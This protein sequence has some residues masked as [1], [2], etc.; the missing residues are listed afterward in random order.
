MKKIFTL[1]SLLCLFSIAT[2]A[3]QSRMVLWEQFTNTSCGPCAGFNP[4]AEAYWEENADKVVPISFHVSWPGANDPM[5]QNNTEENSWRRNLYGCNSVPWTTINGNVFNANPNMGTIQS[6]INSE[7]ALTPKFDITLSHELN[8][9]NSAVTVNMTVKANED[10]SGD[11]LAHIVIIEK[12]IDFDTPPGSN[13]EKHFVNVMKKFLPNKTGNALPA[14]MSAGETI[15]ISQ[16]WTISGFYNVTYL[17]AAGFVQNTSDKYIY[18]AAFSAP[19]APAYNDVVA[20][21]II[22]PDGSVCGSAIEP[23]LK[24]KNNGAILTSVDISYQLND[25]A[26]QTYTYEGSIPFLGAVSIPLPALSSAALTPTGNTLTVTLSNPNGGDDNN[27]ANNEVSTTFNNTSV[28]QRVFMESKLGTYAEELSWK[29][30]DYNGNII[31]EAQYTSA[32]SNTTVK[33]TFSFPITGCYR[34]VWHDSYGDGFNGGGW[35][36][37]TA[38]GGEQFAHINAFKSDKAI[39]WHAEGSAAYNMPSNFSANTAPG[40]I[41]NF[42]W[43]APSKS[44]LSGYKIWK[45][46]YDETPINSDLIPAGTNT[47]QYTVPAEGHYTFYISAVYDDGESERVGPVNV[48]YYDGLDEQMTQ[49][50]LSS[51]PNPTSNTLNT[52]YYLSH[53]AEVSLELLDMTGK[54]IAL[55]HDGIQIAGEQYFETDLS[56]LQQGMY[57]LRIAVDGKQMTHK[58]VKL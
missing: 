4:D 39:Y 52:Q 14:S 5:Y 32:S 24:I 8:A 10:M 54:R 38:E 34:M 2:F 20:H 22:N 51:Y 27:T 44:T 17:C 57:F 30:M 1:I 18:Q 6:K 33:D 56:D 58:I 16:T 13:G 53:T 50:N 47:Y 25:E 11:M 43:T 55:L 37:L 46:L 28:T 9:D 31:K 40:S 41:I 15:N 19:I 42:S 29:V 7:L 49:L 12:V 26:A 23:I 35:C 36:K 48:S 21:A 45:G 3:Q